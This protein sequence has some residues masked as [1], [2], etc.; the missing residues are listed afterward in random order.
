MVRVATWPRDRLGFFSAVSAPIFQGQGYRDV[1]VEPH[2]IS[3]PMSLHK[4]GL[5]G[6]INAD[7]LHEHSRLRVALLDESFYPIPGYSGDDCMAVVEPGLRQKVSWKK[8][9]RVDG[10]DGPVRVRVDWEGLRPED[11]QLFAVYVGEGKDR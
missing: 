9:D 10:I 2:V 4:D 3:C 11:A 5:G 6:Y 7:R 1:T 8:G